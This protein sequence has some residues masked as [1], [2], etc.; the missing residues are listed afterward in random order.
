MNQHL[1]KAAAAAAIAL[2][3]SASHAATWDWSFAGEAGTFVTDGTGAPGTYTISDFSVTGSAVGGTIGSQSGGSYVSG[4]FVTDEPYTFDWDGTTATAWHHLTGANTFNWIVYGQT[5]DT[6]K[7][8]FFGWNTHNVNDPSSA[9]YYSVAAGVDAPI[10]QGTIHLGLAGVV[11]EPETY[12]LM[13]AGLGL[14][15]FVA[16]RR[17]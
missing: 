8:Y 9:A 10:S 5:S 1:Y 3:V 16:R 6:D 12:A 15:G 4:G 2:F 13:L 7:F 14:M 17:R 11:P